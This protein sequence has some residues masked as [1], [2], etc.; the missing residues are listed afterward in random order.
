[1]TVDVHSALRAYL[2]A[3]LPGTSVWAGVSFPPAA[4]KPADGPAVAFRT[5]GGEET[6]EDQLLV[7]SFQFKVYGEDP[8]DAWTN[9]LALDAALKAPADSAIGWAVQEGM[10]TPLVEPDSGWDFVLAYYRV[11]VRN[12]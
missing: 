10:G 12:T 3:Q 7:P 2:A 6:E 9:Y 11:I 4:Y 5:R 1:M 8:K